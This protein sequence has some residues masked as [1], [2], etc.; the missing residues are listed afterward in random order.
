[1]KEWIVTVTNSNLE[2]IKEDINHYQQELAESE[3]EVNKLEGR[4]A[5][6]KRQLKPIG[7]STFKEARKKLETMSKEQ[8][9]LSEEVETLHAELIEH[10]EE[11]DDGG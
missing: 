4:K 3:A 5:E 2:E 6:L 10:I 1:V 7:V 9:E 11:F 8:R